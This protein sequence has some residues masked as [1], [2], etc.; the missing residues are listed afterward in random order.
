MWLQPADSPEEAQSM[1]VSCLSLSGATEQA[2]SLM[3]DLADGTSSLWDTL[4]QYGDSAAQ[5]SNSQQ[6]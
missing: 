3:Q 6:D 1:Y 5:Y 2:P 4:L